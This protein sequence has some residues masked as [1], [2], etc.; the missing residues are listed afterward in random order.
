MQFTY[1]HWGLQGDALF[2]NEL[3]CPENQIKISYDCWEHWVC[4]GG[5][6][7]GRKLI[8]LF[9]NK[10]SAHTHDWSHFVR[11]PVTCFQH[12]KLSI[13]C[14]F[15]SVSENTFKPELV[16]YLF[17]RLYKMAVGFMLAHP[18]GFTRI[19]S[20]YWWPRDIQ[21]GTVTFCYFTQNN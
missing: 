9:F 5:R 19:M 8:S 10:L 1:K 16:F 7:I 13:L 3:T 6:I 14:L 11:V 15:I 12:F 21:N 18:Y 20:S 17:N 4:R 2:G